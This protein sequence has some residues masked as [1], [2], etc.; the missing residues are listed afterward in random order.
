MIAQNKHVLRFIFTSLVLW[1]GLSQ[2]WALELIRQPYLQIGTSDSVTVAWRT[3]FA[4]NGW[5][6]YGTNLDSLIQKSDTNDPTKNH[7]VTITGLLPGERYYYTVHS[8][9]GVLTNADENTFFETAPEVGTEAPV[10]M[11]VVG[12]SGT[13]G[14]AQINVR[15]AMMEFVG[16]QKPDLFLHMGDMAYSDGKDQ[17]FT[18]NFYGIYSDILRNTV[19]WPTMGNHE[20]V[21]SNADNESGPYYEGYVLPTQGEAG[22]LP[23]G[24][25]AYYAFDYA[26]IHFIV[27]ESHQSSR[28]V[29]S[30]MLTW[31]EADI[32]ATDQDWIIAYWH[33]GPYTKGSHDSD[34]ESRHIDMRENALPILEAGGVDLVLAG[35]SHIYERTFLVDGAYDTPTTAEG[36]IVD[37]GDG[38]AGG[39]GP[40]IKSPGLNSHEGAVYVTAGHGGAPTSQSG[41]HPLMYFAEV[42]NGSCIVDVQG[43]RLTLINV[44]FDGESTD[45]FTIMKGDGLVLGYPIGGETINAEETIDIKWTTVGAVPFVDIDYTLNGG[46]L[47]IP[48]TKGQSNSGSFSW[49]TPDVDTTSARVR[50]YATGNSEI[51]DESK[52]GFTISTMVSNV[53]IAYEDTWKYHDQNQ[54]PGSDWNTLEYDDSTWDSGPGQLGYGD[55]DEATLLNDENPNVPTAYFRK[56]ITVET[57]PDNLKLSVLYDDGYAAFI[58]G[59]EVARDNVDSLAF[60]DWTQSG[61]GENAVSTNELG[62]GEELPLQQGEN[63]VAVLVKQRSETSSDLSFDGQLIGYTSQGEA[64]TPPDFT[65][66]GNQVVEIEKNFV[67]QLE[68]SDADGDVLVYLSSPLPN[69]A[70]LNYETGVFSWNPNAEQVGD[71]GIEFTVADLRGLSQTHLVLF[72]AEFGSG[73]PTVDATSSDPGGDMASPPTKDLSTTSDATDVTE[74]DNKPTKSD[75]SGCVAFKGT[76][77]AYSFWVLTLLLGLCVLGRRRN[78]L[79]I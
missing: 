62:I 47:W 23:S 64:N 20:G 79:Q 59:V 44:R 17:E 43:S 6:R 55:D 26:N 25:E 29:D 39:D 28:E 9:A 76:G 27:L 30:P 38:R 15:D 75:S 70:T 54:D 10:R 4:A 42:K 16:D 57:M 3:D 77:D 40:Y 35:H 32:T 33:H 13:G 52:A 61:G 8:A 78:T 1:G 2:S 56:K 50:V 36:H 7:A 66:P 67:L 12:D 53:F 18:D 60:G 34:S 48:I 45:N 21:S 49:S 73:S 11:W 72:T 24:T 22:G 74:V 71:R 63:V 58:N 51:S 37:N 5:V 41:Q 19:C 68:A 69:G 46:N 14:G 31:L 65:D